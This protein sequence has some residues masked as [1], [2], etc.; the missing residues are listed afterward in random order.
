M[1]LYD[2]VGHIADAAQT[3]AF[4][5]ALQL[6]AF[7]IKGTVLPQ[8]RFRALEKLFLKLHNQVAFNRY[9]RVSRAMD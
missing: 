5:A 9:G 8:N 2:I 3:H 4:T 7:Y 1:D 6:H